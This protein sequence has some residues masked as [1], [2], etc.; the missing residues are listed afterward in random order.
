MKRFAHSLA[1]QFNSIAEVKSL[2]KRTAAV[3]FDV[4]STVISAEGIDELADICGKGPEVAEWT[5]K[6]M[7][8]DKTFQESLQ[9]R[10]EL[11]KPTLLQVDEVNSSGRLQ[12]T[13]GIEELVQTLQDKN[14]EVFLVSGGQMIYPHAKEIN[15]PEKNIFANNLLF[16]SD[17]TFKGFDDQEPTSRSGGKAKVVSML[18]EKYNGGIVC[19]IGDGFT[20]LEARPPADLFIGYGGVVVRENV[21]ENAD[22]FVNDFQDLI[23][24]L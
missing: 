5:K 15:I 20:D 17:G 4:D 24:E 9:A 22:W 14:K 7:S 23:K 11:I 10:L 13:P 1:S 6:A 3:C 12:F 16:N 2:W 21:K 8:G 18:K 19:M